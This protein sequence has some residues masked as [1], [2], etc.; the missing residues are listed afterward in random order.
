M[1]HTPLRCSLPT[2]NTGA[3]LRVSHLECE[4]PRLSA[5]RVAPA[6]C[7]RQVLPRRTP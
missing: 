5:A 3:R 6:T 2:T 7:C 1:Q 4:F